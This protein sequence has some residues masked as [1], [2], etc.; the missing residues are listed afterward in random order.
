MNFRKS[1]T[2]IALLLSYFVISQSNT[3][4]GGTPPPVLPVNSSCSYTTGTTVGATQ[5]TNNANFGTPGCASMG[6]D[7]WYTFIAPSSGDV[8]IS[9]QSAGITDGAMALYDS[10]CSSFTELDCDDD[11]G[12]GFMPEIAMSGLTPGASYFIRFW[13]YGGGAGTFDICILDNTP[14]VNCSSCGNPTIV[15]SMPFVKST[16]TCGACD[17]YSSSDACGSSYMNGDDFVYSYT[18]AVDEV[19]GIDLTGTG[20]WTGVFLMDG[21]FLQGCFVFVQIMKSTHAFYHISFNRKN[22]ENTY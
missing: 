19:V 21:C 1:L 18:P 10:D 6:E 4:C 3:P 15:S 2:I 17:N 14:G 9:T 16:S 11:G 20:S 5:Q 12:S 13:D 22:S 7:V 8:T